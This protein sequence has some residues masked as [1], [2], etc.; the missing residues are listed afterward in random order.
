MTMPLPRE[1]ILR[2]LTQQAQPVRGGTGMP[3]RFPEDG[4]PIDQGNDMG[5]PI[6]PIGAADT[7]RY[8]NGMAPRAG[9]PTDDQIR[10]SQVDQRQAILLKKALAAMRAGR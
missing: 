1:D 8:G 9:M 4:P 2:A 6:I 10:N 3:G 5:P 7:Y